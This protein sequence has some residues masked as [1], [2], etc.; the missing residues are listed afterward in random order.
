MNAITGG[1]VPLTVARVAPFLAYF[2]TISNRMIN[3]KARQ[4]LG[5]TG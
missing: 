1:V 3:K 2:L 5:L 4:S